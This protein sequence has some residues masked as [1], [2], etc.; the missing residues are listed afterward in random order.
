MSS[1]G[2]RFND[3]GEGIVT[4]VVL[5]D[6]QREALRLS[7]GFGNG[8]TG[9]LGCWCGACAT[10]ERRRTPGYL[11]K[12]AWDEHG[13]GYGGYRDRAACEMKD[14]DW[15]EWKVRRGMAVSTSG[16][17]WWRDELLMSVLEGKTV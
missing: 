15:G 14:E 1:G 11:S 7:G 17:Y 6:I 4:P 3:G 2:V 8:V 12:R 10:N 5:M 9:G 13:A 16:G